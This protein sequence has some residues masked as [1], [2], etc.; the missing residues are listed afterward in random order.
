MADNADDV[1]GRGLPGDLAEIAGPD[2]ARVY[3][4]I[5]D[6]PYGQG[7]PSQRLMAQ[8]WLRR[9]A[10]MNRY[11]LHTECVKALGG[12]GYLGGFPGVD[13]NA[14]EGLFRKYACAHRARLLQQE[15]GH[16]GDC[17]AD[18]VYAYAERD[19]RRDRGLDIPTITCTCGAR[20]ARGLEP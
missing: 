2:A 6:D 15:L 10:D 5:R 8:R 4:E 18:N 3:S 14:P 1:A 9:L 17:A 19:H 11:A 20:A 7:V 16:T 12:A 13:P